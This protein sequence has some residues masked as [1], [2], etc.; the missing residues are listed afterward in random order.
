MTFQQ[1]L[2]VLRARSRTVFAFTVLTVL[3]ALAVSLA[4]PKKYTA[5]AAVVVDVKSP[6]PIA[7]TVLPGLISPGY[8][9]TQ[10][11]IV[12]SSRVAQR[13]VKR[14]H[15]DED[16]VFRQQWQEA[17]GGAGD[18]TSWVGTQLQRSLDVKPSRESSVIDIKFSGTDPAFVTEVANAFAASYIDIDIELKVQPARQNAEWFEEQTRQARTRLETAQRAYSAY[19]KQTG[20]IAAGERLDLETA[21]LEAL[22]A[23]FS[24]AQS[25]LSD[26]RGKARAA[27]GGNLPEVIQ[28]P[29]VVSLKTEIARLESRLQESNVNL[30]RNHPQ[31]KRAESE[32]ASLRSRL[33]SETRKII[34]GLGTAHQVA[35]QKEAELRS[36][37]Q[38]QKA[39]ILSLTKENDDIS[40]LKR[41]VDSAQRAFDDVSQRAAQTRL[42]SLSV[43]TNV[44]ILNPASIPTVVSSPKIALN[45][46]LALVM[47]LLLGTGIA[48][49]TE[50]ANRRVR[51]PGDLVDAL[52]LPLLAAIPHAAP[53]PYAGRRSWS[54]Q[55]LFPANKRLAVA[56]ATRSPTGA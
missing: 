43:L 37:I 9:A 11:A 42:E 1:L 28:N 7:G 23:Q 18:L 55:R 19:Q 27:S 35:S 8:I 49:S 20:V 51:S 17:T 24:A 5:G 39:R 10:I 46:V 25:E 44:A 50:L 26:T 47:G 54:L 3:A 56:S 14:L 41:D 13:V 12:N 30:G 6:D 33:D 36:A 29:L 16:P 53:V 34:S 2:R 45:A 38:E 22:S 4:L 15:L 52:G 31:T 40:V 32:L 21:R 48:L